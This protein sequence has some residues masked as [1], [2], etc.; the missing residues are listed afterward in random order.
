MAEQLDFHIEK[1]GTGIPIVPMHGWNGNLQDMRW[2]YEPLFE[3]RPNWQR[4]YFDLPGHGHTPGPEWITSAPQLMDAV[5]LMLEEQTGHQPFA[6]SGF[7]YAGYLALGIAHDYPEHLLGLAALNPVVVSDF[8]ARITPDF[9]VTVDDGSFGKLLPA[10]DAAALAGIISRQTEI[11]A[12][13]L[14][15]LPEGPIADQPFLNAIR[16]DPARFNIPSAESQL[17]APFE[18]PAL[19]VTG[20]QDQIS[21]Y[22]Q[23]QQRLPEFPDAEFAL[24]EGAGHLAYVE[25][26]EEV[27]AHLGKWLDKMAA[28]L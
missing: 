11:V 7:S 12:K 5:W 22:E 3:T 20:R 10:E 16:S 8:S 2:L 25:H 27:R 1:I 28:Q 17:A 21:G 4:I 15:S 23:V 14:L 19:F 9:A 18:K 26:S 13:R 6:L 24:F